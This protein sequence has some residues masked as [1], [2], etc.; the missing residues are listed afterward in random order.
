MNISIEMRGGSWQWGAH[1]KSEGQLRSPMAPQKASSKSATEIKLV[2]SD[3][4]V[5]LK[6]ATNMYKNI[7]VL[8]KQKSLILNPKSH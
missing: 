7:D 6:S 2:T 5:V 1:C 3:L 8:K 4:Q